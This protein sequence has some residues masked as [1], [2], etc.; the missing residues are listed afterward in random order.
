MTQPDIYLLGRGKS[1]ELRLKRQIAD[2]APLSDA[3]LVEVGIKAGERVI[4]L[5]C[6]P[7]GVLHLLGKRVGPSGY[8]LGLD[9][10]RTSSNWRVTSRPISA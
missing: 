7:G 9:P 1:E 5:G 4:D 2:L 8:V 10:A 6:G 3:Q